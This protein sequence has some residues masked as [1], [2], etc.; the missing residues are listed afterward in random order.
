[1][2][3][4]EVNSCMQGL[5]QDYYQGGGYCWGVGV[6]CVKHTSLVG[7]GACPP[8]HMYGLRL[9]LGPSEP[10]EQPSLKYLVAKYNTYPNHQ[11]CHSTVIPISKIK[12]LLIPYVTITN[13]YRNEVYWRIN[14]CITSM[15]NITQYKNIKNRRGG[16][17]GL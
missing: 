15:T 8:E 5:I 10:K 16:G 17:G 7:V 11:F 1:M 13:F 9:N 14:K 2:P 4:L 3:K 6:R 12:S